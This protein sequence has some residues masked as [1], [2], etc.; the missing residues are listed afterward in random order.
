MLRIVKSSLACL[1]ILVCTLLYLY[2]ALQQLVYVNTDMGSTDQSAY[3]KYA[4]QLALSRYTFVG[5]RNRMPLYPLMQ[6]LLLRPGQGEAEFWLRG[7]LANL[8]F[9][10]LFLGL[11]GAIAWRRFRPLTAANL[12]LLTGFLVLAFKAGY[13][14]AELL[15]YCLGF[16]LFLLC[17]RLLQRPALWAGLAGGVVAG[18][19]HLTKA[20]VLPGLLIF[21]AVG[22]GGQ[23]Q[24]L[25]RA[26]RA[27][28]G[29]GRGRWLRGGQAAGEG[30][31]RCCWWGWS[32]CW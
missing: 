21:L 19:A 8:G 17:W 10:L 1:I 25:W 2:A 4:R 13:F 23:L 11:L 16:L 7:K 20:S 6:S 22:A 3:I 29:G 5:E 27:A 24:R 9:S 14:Q 12:L 32:S 18:L 28:A 26:R 31:G 15:F 30:C